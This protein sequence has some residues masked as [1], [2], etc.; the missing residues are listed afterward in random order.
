M[1][2]RHHHLLAC[3]AFAAACTAA[4]AQTGPYYIGGQIG[5][6]HQSNVLGLADNE[7]LNPAQGYESK[8]DN[9][10]SLALVGGL[11]QRVG[12]Q[13]VFGDLT[14]SKNKYS[15]N[16]KLD[17]TSYA[18]R[19]GT[20]WE[21]VGNLS[22]NV[23]LRTNR[24]L[25]TYSTIDRP[26]GVSNLVTSRQADFLA[27]LGGVTILTF[28]AGAG[29]RSVDYSDP[30]FDNR[31]NRQTY[32][33]G[34]ARYRPT[35]GTSLG[36]SYRDTNGRYPR[37]R[38]NADD[39]FDRKDLD[40]NAAVELSGLTS[41]SARLSRTKIDYD[42]QDDF[43]GW[44]GQL[45]GNWTPTGKLR[46]N[47]DIARDR[48]QDL[49]YGPD[50][51][52]GFSQAETSRLVN[53][54]RVGADYQLTAKVAMNA[55]LSYTRQPFTVVDLLTGNTTDD[56]IGT[57]R[58]GVGASWAPTRASSVSCSLSRLRR[59]SDTLSRLNQ[60]SN[61]FGCYAQLTLQP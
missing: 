11:D 3:I 51:D 6:T 1:S 24:D 52:I 23:T 28:E 27:R 57:R 15:K 10:T 48:G 7:Q 13:R 60:S 56:N 38:T 21:T 18:L 9:I 25:F 37:F 44:T 42:F 14:V 8:S 54:W 49:R 34:G 40:F 33:M 61:S 26:T 50:F 47:A 36:M 17:N 53:T 32:W 12:R 29:Y 31:D 45:R 55:N 39:E 41:V 35:P 30:S 5:Y 43:S 4:Q 22:G 58:F 46:L 16:D 59:S 20:D 19:A 2:A